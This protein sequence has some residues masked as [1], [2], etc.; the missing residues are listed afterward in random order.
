MALNNS[1]IKKDATGITVVG[2]TDQTFQSNQKPIPSGIY[3]IDIGQ[4]DL[5]LRSSMTFSSK[6]AVYDRITKTWS[7]DMKKFTLN[8]PMI[9]AAGD[10][11]FNTCR[12][13]R[14]LHP[15]VSVAA[16]LSYNIAVAQALVLA[17]YQD[18]WKTGSL[19]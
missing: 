6:D 13:E 11:V 7:K 4:V 9:T 17:A 14:S 2:G 10:S 15:E 8:V 5:R 18:F 16:A 1:V 12:L 3:L 19:A